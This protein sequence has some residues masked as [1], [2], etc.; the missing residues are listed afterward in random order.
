M[1][2]TSIVYTKKDHTGFITLN[3]PRS[4]NAVD[5]GMAA[6]LADVCIEINGGDEVHVVVLKGAGRDFGAGSAVG[7]QFP[8]AAAIAGLEKPVIA[9][10]NGDAIGQ[11]L[12]IVLAC[13]IR[14]AA[15]NARFGFPEV[16]QGKIPSDGGSQRL[17]RIVGRGKA[18]EMLLT[19][20]TIDARTA[21][22]WGLVNQVTPAAELESAAR[23]LA[24][25][26]AAASPLI[27]AL[28]KQAFYAQ[29]DLDQP[30]AY[31]YAKEV[32][33]MN[34]LTADAQEGINAFLEKRAPCWRGL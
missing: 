5:A 11:G 30:K 20:E 22:D 15:E 9:A 26:I 12:E 29:I 27:I 34:A 33:S 3:R 18:L 25:R 28:G 23:A 14:I 17:P 13:D 32:M 24:R 7:E 31:A 4:G 8:A 6:G 21:A 2:E 19:G 16:A 1:S 10:V